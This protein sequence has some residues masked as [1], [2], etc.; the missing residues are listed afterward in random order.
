MGQ[1]H[2]G[3]YNPPY[4]SPTRGGMVVPLVKPKLIG[5]WG[6]VVSFKKRKGYQTPA[7]PFW[8]KDAEVLRVAREATIQFGREMRDRW[9][10]GARK[11]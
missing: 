1:H 10:R 8:P 11:K 3:W 7:R 5:R 2:D 4:K 9:Y 6:S